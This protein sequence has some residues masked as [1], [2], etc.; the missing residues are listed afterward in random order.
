MDIKGLQKVSL[1]DFPGGICSTLF[2]GGCNLRCSY[3]YNKDLV[4]NPQNVP[5]ISTGEI[6]NYLK[7]KS[8][9]LDAACISGGEPTLQEDL[10]DFLAEIKKLGLKVK[11][12]TNGTKPEV[13]SRLLQEDLLDYVALDLKAPFT[14]YTSISGSAVDPA[15]L[16]ETIAL[17]KNSSVEHEFRTTVIPE[18][19]KDEDI[20]NIAAEI[21]G[22]R[23]YVLQQFH[24][25]STMI[26]PSLHSLKPYSREKI[27]EIARLCQKYVQSVQLRGF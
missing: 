15:K 3:C 14:K 12:D 16:K 23:R 17:L 24:P 13:I 11:L 26:D 6:L 18:L 27:G 25:R 1:V 9:F 20:F 10:L 8:S 19:L 21:A 7:Q 4:L 5:T 2:V 22:C